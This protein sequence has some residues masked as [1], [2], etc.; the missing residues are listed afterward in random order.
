MKYCVLV[1]PIVIE[2]G[3]FS[4]DGYD[5]PSLLSDINVSVKSGS[6]VAVVG[7]V[8]SGKSSFLSAILGEMY[9]KSGVV[10]TTVRHLSTCSEF[11][12]HLIHQFRIIGKIGVCASASVD[13]ER[14]C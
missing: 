7:S 6:L 3:E 8:G 4:W 13:K 5:G 12:F 10:N 1:E 2:N 11:P 9:K 14:H